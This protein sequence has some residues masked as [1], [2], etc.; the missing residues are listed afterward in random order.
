MMDVLTFLFLP[1]PCSLDSGDSAWGQRLGTLSYWLCP[2]PLA[3][4][5]VSPEIHNLGSH[6]EAQRCQTP[7]RRA[8]TLP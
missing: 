1:E 2:R 5:T 3:V 7:T 4:L 6:R 8:V